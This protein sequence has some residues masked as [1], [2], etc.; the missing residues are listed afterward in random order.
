MVELSLVGGF[1]SCRIYFIILSSLALD[2]LVGLS[3]VHLEIKRWKR[4]FLRSEIFCELLP[5]IH[6]NKKIDIFEKSIIKNE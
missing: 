1:I 5:F 3:L 4:F 2:L 6:A